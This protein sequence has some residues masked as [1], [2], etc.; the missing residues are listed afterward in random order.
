MKA[1]TQERLRMAQT[2]IAAGNIVFLMLKSS[3]RERRVTALGHTAHNIEASFD[4]D[5]GHWTIFDPDELVGIRVVM[6]DG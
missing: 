2:N 4:D 1:A 6:Q 3:E 5:G